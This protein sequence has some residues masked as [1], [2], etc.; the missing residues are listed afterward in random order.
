MK[1]KI[2]GMKYPDNIREI[3]D[4]QPDY[5]GFIFYSASKRYCIDT[6]Q[7]KDIAEINF[8]IQKVAVFVNEPVKNVIRIATEYEMDILQLHGDE[9]PEY[10]EELKLLDF[11]IIKAFGIDD[12]FD[13]NILHEYEDHCDYF[14]FDTKTKDYGGSGRKFDWNILKQYTLTKPVFLSGG[15]EIQDIA[16]VHDLLK[17]IPLYA[18][19]FNSKLEMDYGKKD[20][21]KSKEAIQQVRMLADF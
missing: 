5:M 21:A 20:I 10:C 2:C 11:T 1:I 12:T 13:F 8:P 17:E 4:L 6:I 15:L 14:M 18:L 16:S 7:Y 19:D 3:A 9:S